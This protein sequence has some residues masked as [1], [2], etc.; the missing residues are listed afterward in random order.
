MIHST[1]L[2]SCFFPNENDSLSDCLPFFKSALDKTLSAAR[3][4]PFYRSVFCVLSMGAKSRGRKG[5]GRERRGREHSTLS[6]FSHLFPIQILRERLHFTQVVSNTLHLLCHVIQAEELR[7]AE[8]SRPKS[9]RTKGKSKTLF[10]SK[11]LVFV[12]TASFMKS[13]DM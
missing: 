4:Q 10:I 5:S 13:L 11:N 6:S 8:E 2:S 1:W 3:Q 7:T 12:V 9:L